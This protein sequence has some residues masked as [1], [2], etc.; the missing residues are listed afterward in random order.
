MESK[1]S[2]SSVVALG[3]GAIVI[4][5]LVYV[6]FMRNRTQAIAG[7]VAPG[8]ASATAATSGA[9]T[10][11]KDVCERAADPCR[12]ATD[13]G[14][15]LLAASFPERA[16]QVVSRAPA[17]CSSPTL[18]A[19]RAESLAAI[20]R[21]EEASKLAA[22]VL[23]TEPQNRFA[24]RAQAIAAIHSK[25]FA[26]ADAALTKL[27]AEDPKDS[28]SLFYLAL[29]QRKR[30]RFNGAREGFLRVLKLDPQHIDARFN[31]VTLT[32]AAGAAQEAEHDYQ[33]LLK[34]APV[35]DA[36]LIAARAALNKSDQGAVTELP[37]LHRS[38]S[39]APA[40]S[41]APP[42]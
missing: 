26:S 19:V 14:V 24:R 33:E 30:D 2:R 9:P 15:E 7:S 21:C 32:A 34:I 3:A 12:C 1:A 8:G 31:L 42:R 23:S 6:S 18:L 35:G 28:D 25:D 11:S 27:V 20:E 39:A 22:T 29:S 40:G 37:T 36:R 4:L 17:S 5:G 16:V 38:N 13:R 10:P 41:V